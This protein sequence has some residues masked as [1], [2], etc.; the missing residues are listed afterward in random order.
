[1][2]QEGLRRHVYVTDCVQVWARARAQRDRSRACSGERRAR[3][4]ASD[5]HVWW[6]AI[7]DGAAVA[8]PTSREAVRF[9]Q[10]SARFFS[11]VVIFFLSSS[12]PFKATARC[13]CRWRIDDQIPDIVDSR[14]RRRDVTDSHDGDLGEWWWVTSATALLVPPFVHVKLPPLAPLLPS[15]PSSPLFS[16]IV[17]RLSHGKSDPFHC[18]RRVG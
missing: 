9:A 13:E 8:T 12:A 1:M 17:P 11:A 4:V 10:R 18:H 16:P 7:G 2:R 5:A 14:G 15:P 6:R 3:V